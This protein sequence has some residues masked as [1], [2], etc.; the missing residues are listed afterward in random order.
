MNQWRSKT[1]AIFSSSFSNSII[2]AVSG[3]RES[4]KHVVGIFNRISDEQIGQNGPFYGKR[5]TSVSRERINKNRQIG[6]NRCI[7]GMQKIEDELFLQQF[8]RLIFFREHWEIS[9]E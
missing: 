1:R 3:I 6:P 2:A 7:L 9:H 4:S 8:R 5:E